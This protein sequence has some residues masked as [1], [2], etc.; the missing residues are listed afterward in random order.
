MKY[1]LEKYNIERDLLSLLI[2]LYT[3]KLYTR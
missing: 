2:I 1:V 3:Q